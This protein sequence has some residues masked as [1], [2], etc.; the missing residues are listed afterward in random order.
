MCYGCRPTCEVC[1]PKTVPCAECGHRN[2]LISAKCIMCGAPL[3][4]EMKE[5]AKAKWE[6]EHNT[7]E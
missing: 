4:E 2:L 6:E 1:R 5:A 7:S 3:T